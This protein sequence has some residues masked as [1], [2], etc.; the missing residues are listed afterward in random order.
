MGLH[1][2]FIEFENVGLGAEFTQELLG[3]FAVWAPGLAENSC[4]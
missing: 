1:T 4:S 3:G 2:D